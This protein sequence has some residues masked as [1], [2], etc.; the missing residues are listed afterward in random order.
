M[1]KGWRIWLFFAIVFARGSEV[2]LHHSDVVHERRGACP[3][4]VSVL[5]QSEAAPD[6]AP[7]LPAPPEGGVV[8]PPLQKPAEYHRIPGEVAFSSL[9]VLYP[10]QMLRSV[11]LLC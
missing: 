2:A 4:A 1:L 8:A 11:V 5:H 7:A 3:V 10:A 9:A 6:V